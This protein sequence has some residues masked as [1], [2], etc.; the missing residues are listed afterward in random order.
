VSATNY[1]LDIELSKEDLLKLLQEKE[2]EIE[3]M[4]KYLN[5]SQ[6]R[7]ELEQTETM[8][9]LAARLAHDLR[10]PLSVIKNV[11]E[12]LESKNGMKIEEKI[13]QYRKLDRAIERISHQIEDVLKYANVKVLNR[14]AYLATDIIHLS[15]IGL[16]IPKKVKLNIEKNSSK[17]YCDQKQM[18]AVF[19]NLILN[20]IQAV[21]PEGVIDVKIQNQD[22]QVKILFIDSG[23]G[24][25]KE[26]STK[27]FEPLFT[28]KQEGTGLGLSICKKIL[29]QHGG[30]LEFTNNPTTF[31]V[32]L[33]KN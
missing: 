26:N 29:E 17:I 9:A 14:D 6:N 2:K 25:T 10:N 3:S 18:I 24:I 4:K 27:I 1:N 8:Q 28:T 20:A 22:F 32:N 33:P 16:I 13:I 21:K 7:L 23:T 19:S 15:T 12:I 30:T 5:E 11:V 31:S